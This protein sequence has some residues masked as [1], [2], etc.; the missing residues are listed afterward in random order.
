MNLYA[1]LDVKAEVVSAPFA[2]PN[3]GISMRLVMESLGDGSSMAAKYPD[4][5]QLLHVGE[6]SEKTGELK[7]AKPRKVVEV[8]VLSESVSVMK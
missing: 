2:A 6:Y 3:D 7:A 8:S 4:D 1:L 5:F